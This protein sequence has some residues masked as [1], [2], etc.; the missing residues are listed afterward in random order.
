MNLVLIQIWSIAKM[1][2]LGRLSLPSIEAVLG[3]VAL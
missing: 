2:E 3:G 1:L